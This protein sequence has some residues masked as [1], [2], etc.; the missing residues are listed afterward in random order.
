M[1]EISMFSAEM[2]DSFAST[3]MVGPLSLFLSEALLARLAGEQAQL[4]HNINSRVPSVAPLQPSAGADG[5]HLLASNPT[6]P[7]EYCSDSSQANL[8]V[9]ASLP[10]CTSPTSVLS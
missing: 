7:L 9:T 5:V 6:Y 10:A 4:L 8:T 1:C 2:G 3:V